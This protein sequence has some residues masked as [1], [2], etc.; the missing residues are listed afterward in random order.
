MRQS[1]GH[2][3]V[4][5][6]SKGTTCVRVDGRSV[7]NVS[8][9]LLNASTAVT[10]QWFHTQFFLFDKIDVG[11]G[12]EPIMWHKRGMLGTAACCSNKLMMREPQSC[13]TCSKTVSNSVVWK[14]NREEE[15]N[16]T[17]KILELFVSINED[18][19]HENSFSFFSPSYCLLGV[20]NPQ[21]EHR[22]IITNVNLAF[23]IQIHADSL[24]W[25]LLGMLLNVE[26]S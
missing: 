18:A 5:F 25:R 22:I 10:G 9:S 20:I 13:K 4:P 15:Y 8:Q 17:R 21:D 16:S 26:K 19:F 3:W 6:G 12:V 7:V 14:S 23:L 1:I 2:C 24:V 11:V